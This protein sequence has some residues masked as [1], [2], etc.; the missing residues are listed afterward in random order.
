MKKFIS[1][2]IEHM[3]NPCPREGIDFGSPNI[4]TYAKI[5]VENQYIFDSQTSVHIIFLDDP[6]SLKKPSY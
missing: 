5:L 4:R 2:W 3:T 1:N 6:I